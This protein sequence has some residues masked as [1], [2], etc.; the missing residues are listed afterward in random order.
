KQ[1]I[2]ANIY[3]LY[4]TGDVKT[5][6]AEMFQLHDA[7]T[8][9]VILARASTQNFLYYTPTF[10]GSS[11]GNPGATFSLVSDYANLDGGSYYESHNGNITDIPYYNEFKSRDNRLRQTIVYPG[12]VRVGTEDTTVND[13]TQNILGYQITKR[14]GE[15]IEDQ[16]ADDRDVILFRYAEVLLNYAEARAI[17]GQLTQKDLDLTLNL[18][19]ERAGIKNLLNIS[20]ETDQ[21]QLS[22]YSR[23]CDPS[24]LEVSRD[25]R[26]ELVFEG[27][28]T[29]DLK[30]WNEGELFSDI[31]K[32]IYIKG[33][34]QFID[35][36]QDGNNDLYVLEPEEKV[37]SDT[38]SGV[39]YLEFSTQNE[40]THGDH[41]RIIPNN[42]VRREI[43]DWEYLKPIPTEEITLNP[44]LEQNPGWDEV[45]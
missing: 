20:L 36:D 33:Y 17:L 24:V 39:Q 2:D 9:E 40:L 3:S 12:Y 26:V 31:N 22:I 8:E 13:F 10:T 43:E 32:G 6:Y 16:G 29:A 4:S 38:K 15:P 30:R 27:F 21:N 28:R 25:R 11:H 41:G 7:P 37:P 23:T 42:K 18:F 34:D 44:K 1:L 5:Q 19:R 14:V 35:L 45:K